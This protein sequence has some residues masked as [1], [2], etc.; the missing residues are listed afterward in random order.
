M[1]EIKSNEIIFIINPNSGNKK[2]DLLVSEIAK[3]DH[4]IDVVVTQT[5]QELSETF[6]AELPKHKVF[7]LV[8]GD[9]TVNE[10]LKYLY[11]Q[12]G[13]ILAVLPAGSGNGFAR[14]LGFKKNLKALIEDAKHGN[15]ME[16][17]VLSIN[18]R[19][20]INVAGLGFDSFV[21][22][23]FHSSTGRGFHNYVRSTLKS[24]FT[25][26]PFEAT[27]SNTEKTITGTYQMISIANTRQFGNNA[28]ISPKSKP[29]N[30]K[31]DLVLVKPFPTFRYFDF[32]F[33]LFAG[34]LKPSKYIDFMEIRNEVEIKSS[35]TKHHVD[36]E[37]DTFNDSLKV[38][39]MEQTITVLKTRF[40]K[41]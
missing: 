2:A 19:L 7:I 31:F 13:K 14:E 33:K 38:K 23:D 28:F 1:S 17:D 41:L 26:K 12:K 8:G 4:Q 40:N 9:G 18:E 39:L 20:C 27:I 22:H 30:R 35:F 29:N 37:P 21:A 11:G 36:G 10:S 16:V 32:V 15:N 5:L 34:T 25:F 6:K 3:I 24:V